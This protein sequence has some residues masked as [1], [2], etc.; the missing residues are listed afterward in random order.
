MAEPKLGSGRLNVDRLGSISL[1]FD[2][3]HGCGGGIGSL[4]KPPKC[5]HFKEQI[6]RLGFPCWILI[7]PRIAKTPTYVS[8]YEAYPSVRVY[9]P[10]QLRLK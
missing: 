4:C 8:M 10:V 1:D 2:V 5:S 7:F 3:M 6:P 9:A